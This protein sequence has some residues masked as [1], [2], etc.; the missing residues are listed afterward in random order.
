MHSP[1]GNPSSDATPGVG[2]DPLVYRAGSNNRNMTGWVAYKRTAGR[3][4]RPKGR[5]WG[6]HTAPQSRYPRA[7]H[8]GVCGVRA[9]RSRAQCITTTRNMTE[10]AGY[11]R[12]AAKPHQPHQMRGPQA[13]PRLASR[14][15]SSSSAAE[16]GRCCAAP[17]AAARDHPSLPPVTR[18]R[19]GCTPVRLLG[20]GPTA[21]LPT[22]TPCTAARHDV[23]PFGCQALAACK[24][25]QAYEKL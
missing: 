6:P 20:R 10:R 2:T 9:Y 23:N 17:C 11:K 19:N 4:I 14:S 8:D 7:V 13:A 5:M 24:D 15:S 25:L 12:T 22:L 1:Y 16:A 18:C 21:M 3:D